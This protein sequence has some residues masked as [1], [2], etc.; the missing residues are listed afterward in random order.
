MKLLLENWREYLKE[1]LDAIQRDRL[2]VKVEDGD[3]RV[4]F[5]LSLAGRRIGYLKAE[6]LYDDR[7][8]RVPETYYVDNAYVGENPESAFRGKGYG[9][10]LYMYAIKWLYINKG[11][12]LVPGEYLGSR[13]PG[14]DP[15]PE[16]YTGTS[17]SA[18]K[19]WSRLK[20]SGFI[21]NEYYWGADQ[22][23]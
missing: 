1:E 7:D 23:S 8:R 5:L 18:R 14:W 19:V 9:T 17:S 20:D 22:G 15:K 2:E 3:Y 16:E 13:I 11:S 21:D 4:E 6:K 12:R 10:H